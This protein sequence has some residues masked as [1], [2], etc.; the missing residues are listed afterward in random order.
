MRAL[1]GIAWT[2]ALVLLA[3]AALAHDMFGVSAA[4]RLLA[5]AHCDRDPAVLV[6]FAREHLV[7]RHVTDY[8]WIFL[9]LAE[10]FSSVCATCLNKDHHEYSTKRGIACESF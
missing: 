9:C 2:L 1:D 5:V 10:V 6:T 8:R 3:P 7:E 4:G